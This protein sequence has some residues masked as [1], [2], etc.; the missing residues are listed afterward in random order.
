M[1]RVR[2]PAHRY[3]TRPLRRRGSLRVLGEWQ[4]QHVDEVGVDLILCVC[5]VCV[6]VTHTHTHT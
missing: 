3:H 6:F 5:H 4:L 2:P 1:Q